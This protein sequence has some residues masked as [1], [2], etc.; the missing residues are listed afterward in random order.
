MRQWDWDSNSRGSWSRNS[1]F[2][3]RVIPGHLSLPHHWGQSNEPNGGP[4]LVFGEKEE[5]EEEERH[6]N[7]NIFSLCTHKTANERTEINKAPNCVC[8]NFPK[9]ECCWPGPAA[10]AA[11]AQ[12]VISRAELTLCS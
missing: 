6:R 11:V 4:N 5:D 1:Y 10:A 8:S 3:Q 7:R 2:S 12:T 9:L